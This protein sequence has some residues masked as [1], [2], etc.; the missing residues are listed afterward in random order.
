VPGIELACQTIGHALVVHTATGIT[1]EAELLA[2]SLAADPDYDLVV[3]DL[4]IDSPAGVWDSLAS[5]V[6]RGRTGVRLVLVRQSDSL[7]P[8]AGYWLSE[9]LGRTVVAP[10][11]VVSQAEDGSLFV[12]S[13]RASGWTRFRKGQEPEW[14]SKRFPRPAWDSPAVAEFHAIGEGS[15]AE[16]LPA[17]MWLRA[18][19]PEAWL[20]ST[21]ARLFRALPCRS[22]ILTVVLGGL[23]IPELPLEAVG[24]FWATLPEDDRMR[25][26]FVPYGP[27]RLPKEGDLGQALADLLDEEVVCYTGMP[28]GRVHA[29]EVFTVRP[30]GSHGWNTYAQQF[31]YRPGKGADIAPGPPQLCGY[32]KPVEDLPEVAP[33]VYRCAPDAV[34]EVVQSGL[35]VRSPEEPAHAAAVRCA[36]ADPVAPLLRYEVG[37]R[38]QPDHLRELAEGVLGRLDYSTR[39]ASRLMPAI[40]LDGHLV[41]GPIE[42]TQTETA[43]VPEPA[44]ALPES[45][46]AP[47]PESQTS[48]TPA[49]VGSEPAEVLLPWLS[50]LMYTESIVSPQADD[51]PG[52]PA[53]APDAADALDTPDDA[54]EALDA[55]DTP[56]EAAG[57]EDVQAVPDDV[58]PEAPI[59]VAQPVP[60]PAASGQPAGPGIDTERAL[61]R[62]TWSGDFESQAESV[63][64][65]LAGNPKLLGGAAN[66][67]EDVLTDAVAVRLYLA[68]AGPDVDRGLRTAEPGPHVAFGRCVAAGLARLPIHRGPTVSALTPTPG[69]WEFCREHPVLTEWGFLNQLVSPYAGQDGDV[70][71]LVWSMTGRLTT[72]LE[73]AE[74][75]VDGRVV[76]PPATRFKVLELVEPQPGARA[77]IL[78]RELSPTEVKPDGTADAN[79][80]S[81]DRLAKASL[82]RSAEG[83]AETAPLRQFPPALVERFAT[84]PGLA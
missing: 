82:L 7:G 22:G 56:D 69:Q 83:W 21:R 73:P 17:G 60:Q 39:L 9:R 12:H 15:G 62:E 48:E 81:L 45:R 13:G 43:G 67:V 25:V 72:L 29:S 51:A 52:V 31:L 54:L 53:A 75:R 68:G 66:R 6:P 71:L 80:S 18:Q 23:G 46:R 50:K 26:R 70:D 84:L 44:A 30:D 5:V 1:T 8:L 35:W 14:E 76:F 27:V 41:A 74:G 37:D 57:E 20:D 4:P 58:E 77:R 65:V 19:G 34:L 16:P 63:R 36:P 78:L 79:R 64:A 10:K 2:A 40:V 3:A 42:P 24:R 38:K 49:A 47:S 55:A 32:R 61:L 28:V 11:G 59:V 33:G